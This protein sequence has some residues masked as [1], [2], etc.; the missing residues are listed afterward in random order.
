MASPSA[1]PAPVPEAIA[2]PPRGPGKAPAAAGGPGFSIGGQKL[3][4][5]SSHSDAD[6]KMTMDR[7][8]AKLKE[9]YSKDQLVEHLRKKGWKVQ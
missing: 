7:M 4:A 2:K 1:G 8:Q 9:G 6:I 3:T 5:P